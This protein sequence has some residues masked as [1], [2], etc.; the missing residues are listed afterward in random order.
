M[1]TKYEYFTPTTDDYWQ[2]YGTRYQAQSFTPATAH[3]ITSVKLKLHKVGSPTGNLTVGIY[4]TS[5][6]RPTGAALVSGTIDSSTISA[7]PTVYE[8]TLGS[9]YDLTASTVYAIML[10]QTGTNSTPLS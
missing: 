1:A 6:G 10:T 8:I 3:K 7:T 5:G 4:A 2:T 9:G